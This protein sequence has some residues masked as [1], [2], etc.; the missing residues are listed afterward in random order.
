MRRLPTAK[1]ADVLHHLVHG[2]SLVSTAVLCRVSENTVAKL[3]L[4]AGAACS[5]FHGRVVRE[6]HQ[7]SHIQIDEIW[8]FIHCKQGKLPIA[9]KPPEHAGDSYTWLALDSDSRFL[10]SWL[11]GDR[12]QV[13]CDLIMNDVAMRVPG[14]VQISTDG[15]PEY[16]DAVDR[17]FGNRAD[18]AQLMRRY[19]TRRGRGGRRKKIPVDGERRYSAP[20]V[21][22]SYV[23]PVQGS[24]DLGTASTAF[25]ERVNLDLR[26]QVKRYGRMVNAFS[27]ERRYL[28]AH[29]ALWVTWHNFVKIHRILRVTPAME[30]GL[31]GELRE[32]EWIADLVEINRKPPAPKGSR[33]RQQGKPWREEWQARRDQA[34]SETARG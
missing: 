16:R 27:K 10:L 1:V 6:L 3:L 4:E 21:V 20:R 14:H 13:H 7:V 17:I 25:V 29:T 31:A 12:D 11:V 8:A 9:R 26:M 19:A 2:C 15:L 24:P 34:R 5:A 28:A 32:I 33:R 18:Y 22:S 23:K 30:L